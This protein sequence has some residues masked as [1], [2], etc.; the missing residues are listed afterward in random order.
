MRALFKDKIAFFVNHE[1]PPSGRRQSTF[2]ISFLTS[3]NSTQIYYNRTP[4]DLGK[5]I[6][7]VYPYPL[8]K[9][10][11]NI[12]IDWKEGNPN[13]MLDFLLFKYRVFRYIK[14]QQ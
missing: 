5:L 9:Y 2:A 13:R 7:A 14:A 8:S 3:N 1:I 12:G 11:N 10:R 4:S 6:P